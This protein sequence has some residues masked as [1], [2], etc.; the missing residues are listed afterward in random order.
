[1]AG[2]SLVLAAS[3][4]RVVVTPTAIWLSAQ[5]TIKSAVR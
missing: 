3:P 4:D 2:T 1:V 5:L